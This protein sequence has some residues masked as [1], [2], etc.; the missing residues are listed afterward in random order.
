[1]ASIVV[2]NIEYVIA[3]TFLRTPGSVDQQLYEIFDPARPACCPSC[4]YHLATRAGQPCWI[5]EPLRPYPG[6][7]EHEARQ[8][9]ALGGMVGDV[10]A[11]GVLAWDSR[12]IVF[13]YLDGFTT[14][15]RI[16][17]PEVRARVGGQLRRWLDAKPVSAY[18]LS[19]NN[20]MVR[21]GVVKLIDFA[22]SP[23][24]TDADR[25]RFVERLE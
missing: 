17:A 2:D 14:L 13:E 9:M 24:K 7:V 5:K 22:Y 25:Q 6:G 21:G 1:M 3:K 18:D 8:A 4:Q 15:A 10:D 23:D 16:T 19:E 20:V 11:V 12:C